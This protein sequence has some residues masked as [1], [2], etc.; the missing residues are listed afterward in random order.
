M[1]LSRKRI[2]ALVAAVVALMPLVAGGAEAAPIAPVLGLR[3]ASNYYE[4]RPYGDEPVYFDIGIYLEAREAPFEL[5]FTRPDYTQPIQVAQI[6]HDPLG[7]T[8]S[9]P[10]PNAEAEWSGI[11]DFFDLEVRDAE[12]Q[13][14]Y[15]GTIDFCPG[16]FGRERINDEG[17]IRSAYPEG[18]FTNPFTRGMVY[19][20]DQNW[21]VNLFGY[22]APYINISRGLYEATISVDPAYAEMFGFQPEAASVSVDVKVKKPIRFDCDK[23]PRRARA[24]REMARASQAVPTMDHPD[25]AILPDL[26]ALPAWGIYVDNRPEKSFLSFGATVWTDG[27]SSMVVEG[28]RR[29][30]ID[31][32][33]AYQYFYVDGEPVGRAQVGEMEFDERRGHEHWHFLQFARYSLLDE[34]QAEIVISKK[35]AFC[36]APTD[37]IDLTVPNAVLNPG[38]IGLGTACGSRNSIWTRET[39]PLGWGDTYQQSLPG[40]SFNITELPNGTYY[41]AVEAN[42][43]G[44]LHE[45]SDT[46]NVEL[47]E[48][49]LSGKLGN[50]KVTVP[51]W[52]GIDTETIFGPGKGF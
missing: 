7:S 18:C 40:Q 12:S 4:I 37:A 29:T 52:N 47:R 20:I 41:I 45:Q 10:L 9:R 34:S 39:L 28:F 33:D 6:L 17:P 32:M 44:S 14:V 3:S 30:D 21:A 13:V 24:Q 8:E 38:E 5:L 16:G 50:R 22:N 23:C 43:T 31:V 35:E 36:L 1:L 2:G 48:I 19:G 49:V 15:S 25:P 27:A 51:P 26:A 46:N 11:P 42:P